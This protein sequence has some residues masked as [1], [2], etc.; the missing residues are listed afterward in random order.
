MHLTVADAV[1]VES[2]QTA[3]PVDDLLPVPLVGPGRQVSQP[4]LERLLLLAVRLV[5]E[6]HLLLFL[7]GRYGGALQGGAEHAAGLIHLF[8]PQLV[9]GHRYVG[10]PQ[11]AHPAH[12]LRHRAELQQA[13]VAS[14]EVRHSR[15][16]GLHDIGK[17]FEV[18]TGTRQ[19]QAQVFPGCL[20]QRPAHPLEVGFLQRGPPVVIQR[21]QLGPALGVPL[22]GM[23][24]LN[25]LGQ[26]DQFQQTG[27]PLRGKRLSLL[28]P[29]AAVGAVQISEDVAVHR[30]AH[31]GGRLQIGEQVGVAVTA[32]PHHQRFPCPAPAV[33]L[34]ARLEAQPGPHLSRR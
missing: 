14:D 1:T 13:G 21:G 11:D 6:D 12:L 30:R 33:D 19:L 23:D 8:P 28:R 9:D 18:V 2:Q 27:Q 34:G 32:P 22:D 17:V 24:L 7:T 5:E 25:E 26:D 15:G 10:G 4:R 29:V 16:A 31:Q 3:V 20:D